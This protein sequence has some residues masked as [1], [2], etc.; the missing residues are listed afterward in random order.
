V[1]AN[2]LAEVAEATQPTTYDGGEQSTREIRLPILYNTQKWKSAFEAN[3]AKKNLFSVL[4][5][6]ATTQKYSGRVAGLTTNVVNETR[7]H[8]GVYIQLHTHLALPGGVARG[9][10]Q[11]HAHAIAALHLEL[12]E[13]ALVHAAFDVDA[14]ALAV[15]CVV[16]TSREGNEC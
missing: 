11:R 15:A 6:A 7:T 2:G 9:G 12:V 5:T 1:G 13:L 10:R 16:S 3:S 8:H 4:T 14:Q